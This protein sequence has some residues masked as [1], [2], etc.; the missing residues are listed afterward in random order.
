MIRGW[1]ARRTAAALA[2]ALAI[3][4][5]GY[6]LG[7]DG[8]PPVEKREPAETTAGEDVIWTCSMHPQIKLPEPGKCPICFMDLIP[9]DTSGRKDS[10]DR[11][12]S[13]SPAAVRLA[14]IVTEPARR[15][16]VEKSVRMVGRVVYDETGLAVISAR[17]PGRIERLHV[18]F[19]GAVVEKGRPLAVLWSPELISAQEELL[20]ALRTRREMEGSPLARATLEAAR[21]RLRQMGITGG[22]IEDIEKRGEASSTVTVYA[23][24]AGT[25]VGLEARAGRYFETGTRLFTIA[26][27]GTVWAELRAYQ[28]DLMWLREGQEAVFATVS[29]P[30]E[31]FSGEVLFI[32]PV[33]DPR[34]MTAGV[35]VEVENTEGLLRPGMFVS[36]SVRSS[37]DAAGEVIPPGE[38]E[39][40][41]PPLTIPA[42]APLLTGRRA[43]VYVSLPGG[44]E[45]VFQGREVVLG[46]KAGDRYLV[47]SGLAEGEMVVV[48]GA[49]KIDAELQIRAGRSMMSP[50]GGAQGPAHDH[51]AAVGPGETGARPVGREEGS[52]KGGSGDRAGHGTG[53]G[54]AAPV[55]RR[56]AEALAPL[57]DAYFD[58][59][60]AL[61]EDDA[62]AASKAMALLVSRTEKVDMALFE[63]EAHMT[64]MA[65]AD[66]IAAH[67]SRGAAAG[68]I[69]AQRDAFYHLSR[70]V[71]ELHEEFGHDDGEFYLTF[72]PMA[73]NNEGAFWIQEVDTVYNSFYGR[74]MLRCGSIERSLPPAGEGSER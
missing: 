59:Q 10:G 37:V 35:R 58:V 53:A 71:I 11:E 60:M 50:E 61:A 17:V 55:N 48:N 42:S 63:G 67:A 73:R 32:D 23:P 12:L 38:K 41:R 6:F 24:S 13:M 20:Q 36:G 74:V 68:G 69:E 66:S 43:V 5:A 8:R 22:Q 49:F 64:W 29:L 56:I 39:S 34:T 4:L 52:R 65:L 30:G 7:G 51:G 26:D 27:L 70:F 46:P 14:G 33:V 15:E 9:L 72:C 31:R 16:F 3:F 47:M 19:T 44:E 2:A 57:Y 1:S 25:V 21:E 62:E 45:P 40:A 18:D 54:E 28:S